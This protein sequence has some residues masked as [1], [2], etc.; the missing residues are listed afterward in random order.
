MA[1]KKVA[2]KVAKKAAPKAKLKKKTIREIHLANPSLE[3]I[4]KLKVPKALK[5]ELKKAIAPLI[6]LHEAKKQAFD[7]LATRI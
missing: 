5:E 7:E 2:K 6:A 3:D 4:D 1:K